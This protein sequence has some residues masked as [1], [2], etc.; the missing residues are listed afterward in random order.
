MELCM[1]SRE[2][3]EHRQSTDRG[4][5]PH[6]WADTSIPKHLKT[7][8]LNLPNDLMLSWPTPP[9]VKLLLLLLYKRNVGSVMGR[10]V[11]ICVHWWSWGTHRKRSVDPHKV[12][13]SHRLRSGAR[14]LTHSGGAQHTCKD[15]T[16]DSRQ[17]RLCLKMLRCTNIHL[18]PYL[19]FQVGGRGT[20]SSQPMNYLLKPGSWDSQ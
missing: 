3:N 15:V 8:V 19:I 9:T 10:N 2:N 18:S 13:A 11:D 4:S 1:C 20:N 16:R 6:L 5:S 17:R 14:S 12:V 7:V